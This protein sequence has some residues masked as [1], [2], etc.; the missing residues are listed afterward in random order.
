MN[1]FHLIMPMGGKGS[2][3]SSL[4][5]NLPKPII[6]IYGKPFFY[7][8]VKSITK[9]NDVIDITFVVLKEHID[10][11]SIDVEIKK[12]FPSAK[13]IVLNHVLNGPVLTCLEGI[14]CISDDFPILINDC[15]HL[16]KSSEFNNLWKNNSFS[17]IDGALIT[18]KSDSPQFSYVIYENEKI[19]GTIEKEVLSNDAICGAYLFKS[20]NQ[21][22]NLSN[23]YFAD[24]KY[25]EYFISGLYNVLAENGGNIVAFNTDYHISFGTPEEYTSAKEDRHFEELD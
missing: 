15:D 12:D 19:V 3:F 16:F 10:N 13:I 20:K 7:W 18:F 2:R 21:F 5:Y 17:N 11:Y 9:F 25:T 24:C 23:K 14:K 1:K 6:P 4:G 8:A 22:V